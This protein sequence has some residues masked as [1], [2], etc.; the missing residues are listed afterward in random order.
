LI[1]KGY[2]LKIYDAY[3]PQRAVSHFAR[4]AE[5]LEDTRMKKYFYPNL[6]KSVL[7]DQGYIDYK[8]GH[9]RGSTLDLTL[10]DMKTEK[11]VDMGGTFDYFG[12]QSHPDYKKITK[13]QYNNRMILRKAMMAHGFKPLSTEWWHFTLKREPYPDTY[14]DFPINFS[15]R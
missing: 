2:R 1:T 12:I 4:W 10:F 14:F 6:D 8:S 5:D 11:E 3:R 13:T 7:F 9:S 15:V